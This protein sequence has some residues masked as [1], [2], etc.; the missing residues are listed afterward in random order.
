[1]PR[2][3]LADDGE[4]SCVTLGEFLVAEGYEVVLA[5]DGDNALSHALAQSFDAAVLN[6]KMGSL[7]SMDVVKKLREHQTTPILLLIASDDEQ[8]M[9][10]GLE[11]GADGCLAKPQ[12]SLATGTHPGHV[13]PGKSQPR[14]I[15]WAS[16]IRRRSGLADRVEN[17]YMWRRPCETIRH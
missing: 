2:I 15:H 10:T 9:I 4:E 1:M 17:S 11:M 7:E 5:H 13:A 14:T 16:T 8:G 6:I 12:S 3:L